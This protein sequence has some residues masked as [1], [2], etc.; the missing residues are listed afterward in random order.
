MYLHRCA[1]NHYDA[2]PLFVKS[3]SG[4]FRLLAKVGGYGMKMQLVKMEL[5][6]TSAPYAIRNTPRFSLPKRCRNAK[7]PR[8][9]FG[10]LS[11]GRFYALVFLTPMHR[12]YS[13]SMRL[14][15]TGRAFCC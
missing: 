15:L 13:I 11:G 4:F 9:A 14:G 1:Y 6:L 8:R 5:G 2:K 7:S 12:R 10:Q 3:G